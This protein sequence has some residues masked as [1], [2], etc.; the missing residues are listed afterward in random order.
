MM[1]RIVPMLLSLVIILSLCACTENTESSE[2]TASSGSEDTSE[3]ANA[4][5]LVFD[6]TAWNY[7]ADND[8]YWQ[9]G[10]VYCEEPV[11]TDYESLGIYVPGTYM[12]G[13]E[14]SNGTYT[15]TINVAGSVEGYTAETAPI[16][17]PVNTAG[18]SAQSSPTSYSYSGLSS[19]IEAG[20]IYV[21]AGCRG[22]DNGTDIDGSFLYSGGAPWGV[23]D[24]KAA[25][26]YIRYNDNVLPG[27]TDAVFSFGHSGGGAQSSLLGATGDSELY[28]DYL[29]SIGAAMTD[30]DGGTISDAITG[31]MCWC[32][33]TSLDYA[34]EANEWM[35][36][37]F[38]DSGTRADNTWTSVFSDDM[39]E[40]FAEYIN[41]LGIKDGD[42]NTL[43]LE[44]SDEGIY[45]SGTYYDYLLSE[46][47]GSLNNFLSDT[48]FPYTSGDSTERADGGFSGG[49]GTT[50]GGELPDGAELP[51]GEEL[52]DM[53]GMPSDGQMP[54]GDSN[55][56]SE[57]VTY[58]TASDYIDALN[59]G[60]E[61]ITY[62]ESTNTAAITTHRGLCNTPQERQQGRRGV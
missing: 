48:E 51:D 38:S 52:P 3:I 25:I 40:A 11:D 18:Y 47:E 16:V 24:L 54:G 22:R 57:S 5:K 10:V 62:D 12:T 36:G 30:D 29:D 41:K 21:Y 39:S 9:I 14:N 46:I 33:I 56:S 43:T 32:P 50:D 6:N 13:T 17:M 37:Q 20:F 15:C 49:D 7:D 28:Y 31:A 19:Y 35:M 59:S 60:E 1:K 2:S 61:W 58:D 55:S 4:G 42:G 26:R 45:T 8:V 34:N 53:G 23:T 27:D 44:K